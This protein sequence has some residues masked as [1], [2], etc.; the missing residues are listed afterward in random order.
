MIIMIIIIIN[1]NNYNYNYNLFFFIKERSLKLFF[2]SLHD[3]YLQH[4]TIYNNYNNNN[5]NRHTATWNLF[6]KVLRKM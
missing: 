5:V 3:N 1:N 2:K 6:V 4:K